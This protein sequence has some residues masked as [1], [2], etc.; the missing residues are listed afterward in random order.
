MLDEPKD[1]LARLTGGAGA[2]IAAARPA[3]AA[4]MEASQ[5]A[6][7]GEGSSPHLGM[8]EKHLVALAVAAWH[9][10]AGAVALYSGTAAAAGASE[11]E[12]AAAT[13]GNA[14]DP[15]LAALMAHAKMLTFAPA[16]S[17]TAKLDELRAAGVSEDGVIAVSQLAA[18]LSHQLRA[19]HMLRLLG[20]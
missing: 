3:V 12:I 5:E 16:D 15:R 9:A 19:A 18:Y 2:E 4:A 8:A 11:A 1:T 20:A 13:G 17:S 14:E 6:L 7:L 10:D